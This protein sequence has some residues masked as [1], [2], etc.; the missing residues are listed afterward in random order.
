[1]FSIIKQWQSFRIY[2]PDLDAWL[3]D[4]GGEN[5]VGNSADAQFTMWFTEQPGYEAEGA[6]EDYWASLT[7]EGEYAKWALY[8]FRNAAV[9]DAREALLTA[10]FD[11]LIPAERKIL[12][13]MP[14]SDSD[15]DAILVKFPQV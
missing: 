4:L 14:L 8:T 1:M 6:V 13:G 10:A 12:L 11:D 2:L 7:E 5:Y 15:K 3:K 9:E